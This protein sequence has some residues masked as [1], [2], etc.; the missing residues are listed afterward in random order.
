MRR[1]G[2][3]HCYGYVLTHTYTLGFIKQIRVIRTLGVAKDISKV[4]LRGRHDDDLTCSLTNSSRC[5]GKGGVTW[6]DAGIRV[7]RAAALADGFNAGALVRAGVKFAA[8]IVGGA[9]E[10]AGLWGVLDPG[11]GRGAATGAE[12]P[13]R[14]IVQVAVPTH[15]EQGHGSNECRFCGRGH[16]SGERDVGD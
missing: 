16:W 13:A 14:Q 7:R 4:I 1:Q 5:A 8:G 10:E 2:N 9:E 12:S 15:V 6:V 3:W 11:G